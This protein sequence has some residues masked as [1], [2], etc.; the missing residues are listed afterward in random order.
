[1]DVKLTTQELKEKDIAYLIHP[2]TA[3]KEHEANGPL[4]ITRGEGSTIFDSD[5]RSYIDSLGGLWNCSLG[6]GRLDVIQAV[7]EQMEKIAF[8]TTFQGIS[9]DKTI[10]WAETLVS[11][12][13]GDLNKVFPNVTGSEA[14]D[15]A[16]KFTRMYHALTNRPTKVKIFSHHRGYHGVALG[17]LSATGITDFWKRYMPLPA[18]FVHIPAPHCYRCPYG[19]KYPSCDLLCTNVLEQMMIAEDPATVGAFIAEPVIGGGGV[20]IPPPEYYNRVREICDRHAVIF[21]ADEVITGFGRTGKWFGIEHWGVVPDMMTMGKGMTAGYLPMFAAAIREGIYRVLADSGEVLFHGFTYT[22]QPAL[23]AAA[24]K[25]MQIIES[26]NL[27]ERVN[28]VGQV[29]SE[30]LKALMDYPWVGNVRSLGLLGG[31]EFVSDKDT[32]APLPADKK[33]SARFTQALYSHGVVGRVVKGDTYVMAPPFVITDAEM[34]LLFRG[35]R[36]AIEEVCPTL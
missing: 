32:K 22:G 35:I 4:V 3:L 26:E 25:V 5:G 33:F 23:C 19:A 20:I 1:M 7:S 8:A 6:H 27:I 30:N 21:I 13:P 9:N 12:L 10:E 36:Q 17:V 29:F 11:H 28:R 2:N 15:T 24:V 34:Q 16:F 18:Y 31:I 14:N